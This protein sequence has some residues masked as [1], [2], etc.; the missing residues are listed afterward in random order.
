[1]LNMEELISTT[2]RKIADGPADEIWI[3]KFDVEYAYDQLQFSK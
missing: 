3:S 1:M 2:H